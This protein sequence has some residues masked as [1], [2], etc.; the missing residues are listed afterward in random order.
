MIRRNGHENG[1]F[2]V[3]NDSAS[4]RTTD[5]NLGD[6]T[7]NRSYRPVRWEKM[8]QFAQWD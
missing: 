4:N 6:A 1:S 7:M 3:S 8:L 5:A 2:G